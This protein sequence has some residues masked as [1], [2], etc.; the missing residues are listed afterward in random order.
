[1]IMSQIT[2]STE[3]KNESMESTSW[4]W[5]AERGAPVPPSLKKA[6]MLRNPVPG[7]MKESDFGWDGSIAM[8]TPTGRFPT[9]AGKKPGCMAVTDWVWNAERSAP[10]PR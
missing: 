1:M 9:L 5:D 6:P 7:G 4:A 10:E 3:T 2:S 8:A